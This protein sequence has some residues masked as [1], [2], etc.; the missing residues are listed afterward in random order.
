MAKKQRPAPSATEKQ[1]VNRLRDLL[2]FAQGELSTEKFDALVRYVLPRHQM[3]IREHEGMTEEKCGDLRDWIKH[4]LDQIADGREFIIDR[5]PLRTVITRERFEY[6]GEDLIALYRQA[7]ATILSTQHWRMRRCDRSPRC[8]NLFVSVNGSLF[9][10]QQCADAH[11][12]WRRRH[13][14]LAAPPPKAIRPMTPKQARKRRLQLLARP[15]RLRWT[16]P[17]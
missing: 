4:G 10:S 15:A 14:T 2:S 7:V 16:D 9:C 11:R 5:Q 13:P 12:M 6:Q 3:T 17:D 1:Q 8:Q